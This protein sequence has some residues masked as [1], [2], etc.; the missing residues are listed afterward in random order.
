[1]Q[2]S[3]R[4]ACAIARVGLIRLRADRTMKQ[5][6][7]PFLPSIRLC[8][9]LA[10]G[11]AASFGCAPAAHGA[12]DS[13]RFYGQW[14]MTVSA[15]GQT[16][17]IISLHDASGFRNYV[18]TPTGLTFAG[19]GAF[20]AANGIW[21]AASPPPNNG[22]TYRFVDNNTAICSNAIGQTVTWRRDNTPLGRGI[23]PPSLPESVP[24]DR[25]SA[26]LHLPPGKNSLPQSPGHLEPAPPS[27][28]G[29]VTEPL[30]DTSSLAPGNS[31][32]LVIGINEY[33]PPLPKLKTASTMPDPSPLC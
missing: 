15:N 14:K 31:Y 8:A 7:L 30:P 20:S 32:A 13:A 29:L 25:S 9:T 11:L 28:R 18:E 2:V 24:D 6:R 1:L 10:A 12:D 21:F 3:Y 22:G 33:P 16:L 5:Q 26:A 4:H 17:T 23:A 19:S 27:H